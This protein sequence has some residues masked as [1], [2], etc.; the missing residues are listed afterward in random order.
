MKILQVCAYAAPY[1]GN[2]MRSL[3]ALE[4]EALMHGNSTVYVLPETVKH[5]E[6]CL[7][8]AKQKKV[9]FLPVRRARIKPRTYV[10]LRKIFK[11]HPDIAIVHSH[12]EL[13][14]I[15]VTVVAPKNVKIFWH[16]HD[17]ISVDGK[18][19]RAL[20]TYIQ[21][22]YLSKRATLLSVADKYKCDVVEMGF[23]SK[24]AF[25]QTNGIDL[26]RIGPLTSPPPRT[27]V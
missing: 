4:K 23:P 7:E 10:L 21:Y 9:Y 19:S 14:D 5:H 11:E 22:R 16:L 2:F 18:G 26:E 27:N 24:Q 3:Y 1:E 6:W 15:P 13:Y 12:F 17:A 8:L 25:T 20:L